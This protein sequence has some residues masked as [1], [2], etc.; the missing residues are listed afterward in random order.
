MYECIQ[1]CICNYCVHYLYVTNLIFNISNL[2]HFFLFMPCIQSSE[3]FS[4][5]Y[6]ILI[7]KK[8]QKLGIF[9]PFLQVLVEKKTKNHTYMFC[10]RS[11]IVVRYRGRVNNFHTHFEVNTLCRIMTQQNKSQKRNINLHMSMLQ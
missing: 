3:I 11:Q 6:L 9:V 8:I 10:I 4:F 1:V 5:I 2:Y 7:D